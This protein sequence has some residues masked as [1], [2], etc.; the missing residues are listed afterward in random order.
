MSFLSIEVKRVV[1][2]F[3]CQI[4]NVCIAQVNSV[5]CYRLGMEEEKTKM[6]EDFSFEIYN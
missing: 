4:A 3:W 5:A 1:M 2:K 6:M